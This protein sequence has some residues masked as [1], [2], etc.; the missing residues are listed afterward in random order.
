MLETAF[1]RKLVARDEVIVATK[2]GFIPFDGAMPRDAGAYFTETYLRPGIVSPDD[3]TVLKAAAAP[4]LTLVT[5]YPFDYFGSAPRRFIVH[6][7][8]V[9]SDAQPQTARGS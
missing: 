8:Q 4:T 5:C 1:R 9:A 7:R 2:G 6:A 3:V